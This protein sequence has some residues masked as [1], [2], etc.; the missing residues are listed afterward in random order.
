[1]KM[2][3]I[4]ILICMMLMTTFITVA[5]PSEKVESKSS[6]EQMSTAYGADIPVW[7]IGDKWTYK[8]DDISI[9]YPPEGNLINLHLSIAEIP[10]TVISTT[11]DT[12]TLEYK[13]ML[14]GQ[15]TI[16][17]NTSNGPVNLSLTFSKLG[18]SGN[19][20]IDKS[21]L[22]IKDISASFKREKFS[23]QIKQSFIPLPRFFQKFSTRIT[24]NLKTTFD[25][26]LSLLTFPL[27][28]GTSW[29]LTSTNITLNGNIQSFYLNLLNFIN[30]IAKLF[31]KE[32]LSPEISALLPIIDIKEALTTL[33][34]GNVFPIS[35]TPDA[36]SC[37]NTENI[38]VPAGIYVAYNVTL[39][40]G[41]AQCYYA[42][43]AGNIVKLVGNS[44]V[45]NME[46]LSTNYS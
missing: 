23:I 4:G 30:K 13:T 33:G 35:G 9:V 31:G 12:Y 2:K 27:N 17:V 3:I 22:G 25:T 26:P 46:L 15:F 28:T 20:L 36:F 21:T 40:G 42:P 6:T 34:S 32:F 7:K 43:T 11:G 16:N 5:K 1:M 14:N 37:L 10:L 38:N 29:N 45:F 24:M 44:K 8:I 41:F 19:V 39:F 18:V